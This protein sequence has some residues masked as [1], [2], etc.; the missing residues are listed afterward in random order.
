VTT[1][2][3]RWVR[4]PFYVAVA[5]AGFANSLVAANWFLLGMGSV[6][7]VLLVVRTS[8]EE[9]KLIER[10]GDDYREYMRRTRFFPRL[11]AGN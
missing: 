4:H 9:E 5:L 3:H 8:K 6:V 10:F 11:M 1:G 2:P 7:F